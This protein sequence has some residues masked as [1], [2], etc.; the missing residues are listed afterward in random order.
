ML[1]RLLVTH[2]LRQMAQEKV[3]EAASQAAH[4]QPSP[5]GNRED[6]STEELPVCDIG[7]VFATGVESGGVV[8]QLTATR[9]TSSPALNEYSGVFHGTRVVV[10]ESGIGREAAARATNDLIRLHSP[11]WVISTGFAA[12][13]SPEL[14]RGHLLMPSRIVD[15]HG[16]QLEVGFTV[17]D[18]VAKTNSW[19]HIG[20][21]L[22]VD[23]V[24][25]QP[26]RRRALYQDTDALACDMESIAVAEMCRQHKQRFMAV[27]VVSDA[28]DDVLPP[29]IENLLEQ[30]SWAGKL[31]AASG[32]ML[33][34]PATIKQWWELKEQATKIS[35]R[36]ARFL[37][38]VVAQLPKTDE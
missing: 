32:A 38:G 22:T 35:D 5:T 1:L 12:A 6:V 8:D 15:L 7:I 23:E 37:S 29:A 3:M 10:L 14:E 30:K 26:A 27:R 31:G 34:S 17:S 20:D 18:D 19:L 11:Q 9:K 25:R 28:V 24:I 2:L 13:L 21:L 4:E 36:L 33:K 16:S